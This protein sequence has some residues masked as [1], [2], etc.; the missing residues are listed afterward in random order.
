MQARKPGSKEMIGFF[1]C[2]ASD[3]YVDIIKK[4]TAQSVHWMSEGGAMEVFFYAGAS[5]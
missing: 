5:P 4:E 2:N 3:T 1:W